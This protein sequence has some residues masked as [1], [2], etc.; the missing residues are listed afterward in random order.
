MYILNLASTKPQDAKSTESKGKRSLET[1]WNRITKGI[2][3]LAAKTAE[4][5][6]DLTETEIDYVKDIRSQLFDLERTLDRFTSEVESSSTDLKEG[7]GDK[8]NNAISDYFT[9]SKQLKMK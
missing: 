8:W 9:K 5:K 6:N 4:A 1:K 3:S 7:D 2:N